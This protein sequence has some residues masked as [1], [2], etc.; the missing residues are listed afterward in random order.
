MSPCKTLTVQKNQFK[1][2]ILLI[3]LPVIY[4]EKKTELGH[5]SI[6]WGNIYIN[7]YTE[8]RTEG[9]TEYLQMVHLKSIIKM[10]MKSSTEKHFLNGH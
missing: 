5:L 10:A 2:H 4:T 6:S 9:D 8:N 1:G 3:G 7:N